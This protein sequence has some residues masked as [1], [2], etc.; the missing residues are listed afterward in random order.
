M[1]RG[2]GNAAEWDAVNRAIPQASG[3]THQNGAS[4]KKPRGLSCKTQELREAILE[5]FAE[6]DKPVTVRQM[7]Y[8]MTVR[9]VVPKTEAQGYRPVQR[10]LVE[11]RRDGSIPYDWIAD[12]T[13]WMRK[14]KTY[15][16]LGDFLDLAARQYRQSVWAQSGQYGEIWCEKDALAGVIFPITSQYDVP[17]MVARGYSSE[18]FVYGA[19]CHMRNLKRPAFVCYLGDFDPSGWDM[20]EGLKDKLHDLGA[21]MTFERLAVN[22]AQIEAWNL[23]ERPSK[24]TDTRCK[25]FF[26]QFGDGCPS[27][28]LDAVP[29]D[30]L[31]TLVRDA[32]EKHLPA[33]L[34]EAV[35]LEEQA[36]RESLAA[37]A[38]DWK[39]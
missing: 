3:R 13:R 14:P 4:T 29:P 30:M 22:P 38:Q 32:I 9:G 1:D 18:S 28:E 7:F 20:S 10:Q 35:E 15:D 16:S 24:T 27:V 8:M 31:R 34:L 19:A 26:Q 12:N 21:R 33:G 23:P 5:A 11:M 2:T 37:I 6:T 36:A 39:L 25:R 17:L